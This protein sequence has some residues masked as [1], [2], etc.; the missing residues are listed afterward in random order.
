MYKKCWDE[1]ATSTLTWWEVENWLPSIWDRLVNDVRASETE[2][3][4]L[5]CPLVVHLSNCQILK[6]TP[7]VSLCGL[8]WKTDAAFNHF[9]TQNYFWYCDREYIEWRMKISSNCSFFL[10]FP[11]YPFFG[12]FLLF[13][14]FIRQL[15]IWFP[16]ATF[17]REFGHVTQYVT[18]DVSMLI[19]CLP[20]T[21]A[22]KL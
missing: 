15:Q 5:C 7:V 11:L 3:P 8:W 2:N 21:L 22:N 17:F 9:R 20:D 1:S 12:L 13:L 14:I 18:S 19:K 10:F 6:E 4:A 16:F